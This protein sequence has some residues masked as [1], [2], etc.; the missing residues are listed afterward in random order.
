MSR[1]PS[2]EYIDEVFMESE[3]EE[4]IEDLDDILYHLNI[5]SDE[6]S[7]SEEAP[8]PRASKR[9]RTEE[10]EW[11]DN[12]FT[13]QILPF[14]NSSSG[15]QPEY[16]NTN[17]ELDFFTLFF[18]IDIMSMLVTE[19]NRY[20]NQIS[21]KSKL[22]KW[23]ETDISEMYVFLATIMLSSLVGK[24]NMKEYWST[25]PIIAKQFKNV[26]FHK[27]LRTTGIFTIHTYMY[28]IY[29]LKHKK[30]EYNIK[31]IKKFYESK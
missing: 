26:I 9:R 19:T 13:P 25:N 17:T 21:A 23:I 7:E 1:K 12:N 5:S 31:W 2:E 6:D 20:A 3:D 29:H 8:P 30:N 24:N 14:E 22:Q 28:I 15:I 18:N 4:V 27:M 10:R 16:V 11:K